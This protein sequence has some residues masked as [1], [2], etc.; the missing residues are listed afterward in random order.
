MIKATKGCI[1]N[2]IGRAKSVLMTEEGFLKAKELFDKH[3]VKK[4]K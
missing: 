3:F 4:A 1:S 2:P